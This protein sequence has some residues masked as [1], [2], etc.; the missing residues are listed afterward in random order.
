MAECIFSKIIRGEIPANI[1]YEDDYYIAFLDVQP[2]VEGHTLLVPKKDATT[3][4]DLN[5]EQ[6]K[7][8]GTAMYN[9]KKILEKKYGSDLSI[10]NS[11]GKGA[12]QEVPYFHVH[13]IPREKGDRLWEGENSL[14]VYDQS[15]GFVRLKPEKEKLNNLCEELKKIYQ[16]V[17]EK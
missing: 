17:G 13:F 4:D 11:N 15:S 5:E 12:S 7:A 3:L 10:S 6:Q 2:I 8:L 1:F 9:V 14:I 16:E